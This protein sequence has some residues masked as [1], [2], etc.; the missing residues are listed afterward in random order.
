MPR[1]EIALPEETKNIL[2]INSDT[3]EEM[4]SQVTTASFQVFLGRNEDSL[5]P[6]HKPSL[7]Q[8]KSLQF[9]QLLL[10][11]YIF[12]T[13]HQLHCPYTPDLSLSHFRR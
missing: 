3:V 9:P 5:P 11:E 4:N 10:A 2:L 13:F 6:H 1:N 12:Q 8:T 7:L